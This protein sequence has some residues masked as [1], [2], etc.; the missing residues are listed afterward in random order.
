MVY[1]SHLLMLLFPPPQINM[2]KTVNDCSTRP[3]GKTIQY[4]ELDF[5][6]SGM[7]SG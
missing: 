3:A 7:E 6:S 5:L 4:P 1:A 2:L